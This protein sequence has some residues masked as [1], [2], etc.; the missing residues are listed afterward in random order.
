M[1]IYAKRNTG[2]VLIV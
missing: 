1:E 2:K